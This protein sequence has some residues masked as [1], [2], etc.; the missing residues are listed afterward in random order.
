M[1]TRSR[2]SSLRR[3][4]RLPPHGPTE[5]GATDPFRSGPSV[6]ARTRDETSTGRR[7]GEQQPVGDGQ[8]HVVEPFVFLYSAGEVQQ[9]LSRVV[10]V[11]RAERGAVKEEVVGDDDPARRELGQHQV[12]VRRVIGLPCVDPHNVERSR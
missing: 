6:A 10:V 12:K 11:L 3:R 7:P 2:L 1:K 5:P 9:P 8:Q 4:T